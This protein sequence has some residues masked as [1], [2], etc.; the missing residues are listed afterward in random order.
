[1]IYISCDIETSGLDPEK[2]NILSVGAIIED[3]EKKLSWEEI[4]KFHVAIT[5]HEITGSPFAI[6]MNKD[7]I[8]Q[9][10]TYQNISPEN[11]LLLEE[12]LGMKFRTK[13]YVVSEFFWW[14]YDNGIAGDLSPASLAG[15]PASSEYDYIPASVSPVHLN[16]AG[17]NFGTFDKLFL[18]KLPRWKQVIRVRQRIIDPSILLM[19]WKNDKELPSLNKCKER[20][21]LTGGVTHNA[22]DDAW[23][24]I[25]ILRK[26]Y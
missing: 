24:V 14:L 2:N 20:A 25:Q 22:L 8:Q 19:D 23:D 13:D 10:S 1:M 16:F 15:R 6:N 7:L 3:T 17:K 21:G 4:P 11:R 5:Q 26:S 18:E 9:I 12:S